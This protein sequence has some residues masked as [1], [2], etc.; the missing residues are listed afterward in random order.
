MGLS[1]KVT[2]VSDPPLGDL[3]AFRPNLIKFHVELYKFTRIS[4]RYEALILVVGLGAMPVGP[5]PMPVGPRPMPVGPQPMP[6]GFQP[7][8]VGLRPL[9]EGLRA[10]ARGP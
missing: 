3:M 6:L 10:P 9:L 7:M 2:Q 8:P 1:F 4:G 5:R